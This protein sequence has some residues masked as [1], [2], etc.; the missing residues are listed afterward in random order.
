MVLFPVRKFLEPVPDHVVKA[1]ALLLYTGRLAHTF[2]RQG[3]DVG[4]VHGMD[5]PLDGA[6]GLVDLLGFSHTLFP[7]LFGN[8]YGVIHV[9][10]LDEKFDPEVADGSSIQCPGFMEPEI[11]RIPFV[12]ERKECF[13]PLAGGFSAREGPLSLISSTVIRDFRIHLQ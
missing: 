1:T 13:L 11:G 7:V 6:S 2:I 4:K 5:V 12:G 3:H 8:G 10:P 9:S